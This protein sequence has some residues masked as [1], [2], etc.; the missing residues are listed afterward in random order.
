MHASAALLLS[1]LPFT[2]A[3]TT[4]SSSPPTTTPETTASP[5]IHASYPSGLSASWKA[6]QSSRRQIADDIADEPLGQSL[7]A[8]LKT[9]TAIPEEVLFEQQTSYVLAVAS[10]TLEASPPFITALPSDIQT[11]AT[12]IYKS[13]VDFYKS[14]YV[15]VQSAVESY[16]ST[17][18][19]AQKSTHSSEIRATGSKLAPGQINSANATTS[20][21]SSSSSSV[22]DTPLSTLT[23]ATAPAPPDGTL[24]SA[25]GAATNG[26]ASPGGV[27]GR[28][29]WSAGA[30]MSFALGVAGVMFMWL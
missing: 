23:T 26:T 29:G 16:I 6:V 18:R 9:Q 25:N 10:G 1:L 11:Y 14:D 17:R 7:S 13:A 3:Q 5:Q 30:V 19:H 28:T 2:F 15:P 12:H 4:T 27:A 8:F 21:G 20:T 22:S 24:T